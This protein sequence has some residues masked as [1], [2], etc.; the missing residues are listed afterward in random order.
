M[1]LRDMKDRLF[2]FP[3]KK[4]MKGLRLKMEGKKILEE[5]DLRYPA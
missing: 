1:K 2:S 3:S 5:K 4:E